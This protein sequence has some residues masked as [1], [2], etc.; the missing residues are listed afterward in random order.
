[1][2]NFKSDLTVTIGIAILQCVSI[3]MFLIYIL[4]SDTQKPFNFFVLGCC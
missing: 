2:I 4:L 3:M 1:M